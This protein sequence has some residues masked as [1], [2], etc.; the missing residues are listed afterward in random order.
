MRKFTE[1][2]LKKLDEKP[3]RYL[4]TKLGTLDTKSK[5]NGSWNYYTQG[6]K[7]ILLPEYNGRLLNWEEK[8]ELCNE[9]T[10]A[11]VIEWCQPHVIIGEKGIR[12]EYMVAKSGGER[13]IVYPTF[14]RLGWK[15]KE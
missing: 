5:R 1:E 4:E 14:Y 11:E 12:Y 9:G 10:I 15:L 8:L 6:S 7:F 2:E 13:F 3:K